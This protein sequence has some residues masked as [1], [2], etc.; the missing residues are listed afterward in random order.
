MKHTKKITLAL[1][2]AISSIVFSQQTQVSKYAETYVGDRGFTVHLVRYGDYSNFQ[3]LVKFSG[4][5]HPWDGKV[6]LCKKSINGDKYTYT[7]KMGDT[8]Y[9]VLTIT[10]NGGMAFPNKDRNFELKY[11]GSTFITNDL[12]NEYNNQNK[13]ESKFKSDK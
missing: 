2:L 5:D 4:Y 8:E 10:G 11:T 12:L 6:F 3:A 13:P 7:T 1:L 9:V